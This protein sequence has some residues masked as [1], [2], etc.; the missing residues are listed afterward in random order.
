[1]ANR[2]IIVDNNTWNTSHIATV[3]RAMAS[4]GVL[5]G[6]QGCEAAVSLSFTTTVAF[7]GQ[8]GHPCC[9]RERSRQQFHEWGTT[10]G[11][12]PH[13][14]GGFLS[15]QFSKKYT[16]YLGCTA[17]K[18]VGASGEAAGRGVLCKGGGVTGSCTTTIYWLLCLLN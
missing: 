5:W 1:M 13:R 15:K 4:P 10:C 18:G 17:M 11:Q 16:G 9:R 12:K 3:G 6:P 8:T 2:T 7:P 14:D